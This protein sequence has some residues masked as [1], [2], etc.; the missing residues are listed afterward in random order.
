MTKTIVVIG[1]GIAALSAMEKIRQRD[2]E[3]RLIVF[4]QEEFQTY[5]R[6]ELSKRITEEYPPEEIFVKPA[7]WYLEHTVEL[8]LSREILAIDLENKT[9]TDSE[10]QVTQFSHLL[11]ANGGSNF[12]P[13]I[14]GINL[15]NVFSLRTLADAQKI[16]RAAS[17]GKRLLLIGGGLL[18]L[19]M[20]WQFKQAGLE[21]T[22]VEMFPQLMPRQLD[23]EASK[24]L[25]SV[26]AGHGIELILGSGV[27]KLVG[28]EVLEGYQLKDEGKVREAD[29][30]IYSTGMRSNIGVY[31]ETGLTTN[32]GVVVDQGMRT[33]MADVY[34]AGDIAE[35]GGRV[36]GLWSAARSQ[37]AVAGENIVGGNAHFV[38]SN[39]ITNI[40]VFEQMITSLGEIQLEGAVVFKKQIQDKQVLKKLFFNGDLLCGALFLNDQKDVLTIR[41]GLEQSVKVPAQAKEDYG[42][43]LNYINEIV[44][45]K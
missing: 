22:I 8:N 39:P 17:T 7:S 18:G 13:P 31:K 38:A 5:N 30:C 36:Y 23:L 2:G 29:L 12:V 10:G 4:S 45:I 43:V 20:A 11:L 35:Y 15:E 14:P 41:K 6:L 24:Y 37:G 33:N 3:S 19:E 34:A 40:N 42:D 9:V 16:Q 27:E 25:E 44:G 32:H 28:E 26:I 1:N 21:I